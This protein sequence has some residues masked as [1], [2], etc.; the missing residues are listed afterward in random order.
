MECCLFFLSDQLNF[1]AS[2]LLNSFRKIANTEAPILLLTNR[3]RYKTYLH[4]TLIN[5][6]NKIFRY[7]IK[8]E[9]TEYNQ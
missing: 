2:L 6:D 7:R 8:D 1:A 4:F 9:V 3:D 5:I